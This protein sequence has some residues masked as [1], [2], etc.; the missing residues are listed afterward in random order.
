MDN[1][2]FSLTQIKKNPVPDGTGFLLS[3]P[4]ALMNEG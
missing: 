1:G 3:G 2:Y 4:E